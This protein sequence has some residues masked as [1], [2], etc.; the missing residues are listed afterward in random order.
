MRILIVTHN[1]PS[2]PDAGDAAAGNLSVRLAHEILQ[3][4]HSVSVFTQNSPNYQDLYTFKVWRFPWSG[5]KTLLGHLKIWKPQHWMHFISLWLQGQREIKKCV[6]EFDPELLIALWALPAGHYCKQIPH[7]PFVVWCLGSDIWTYGRMPIFRQWI[8]NIL[9]SAKSVAADGLALAKEVEALSGVQCHFAASLRLPDLTQMVSVPKM[10]S[11][12]FFYCARWEKA[13]APDLYLA[14]CKILLEKNQKLRCLFF[15]GGSLKV[16]LQKDLQF[17]KNRFP[18]RFQAGGYLDRE[19]FLK[20]LTNSSCYVLPSREES[21]P[22]ALSDSVFTGTPLVVSEAGD[23]G[24]IVR[25]YE[26]GSVCKIGDL[27]DLVRAMDEIIH[28]PKNISLKK[29]NEFFTQYNMK[30]TVNK[31]LNIS[32]T[33]QLG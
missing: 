10:E 9:Q 7:V 5:G 29:Q 26:L 30:N 23:M 11:F 14:A 24:S 21:I 22:M 25:Q 13:K 16:Q 20:M 2:R 4:G 15:G 6:H 1:F 3:M 27:N 17:L 19:A 31:L 33:G 8:R 32:Q 28:N 18:D 12:Q